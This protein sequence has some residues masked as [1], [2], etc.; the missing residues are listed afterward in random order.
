MNEITLSRDSYDVHTIYPDIASSEHL[1]IPGRSITNSRVLAAPKIKRL[2]ADP[3]RNR[4]AKPRDK[5]LRLSK[6][7]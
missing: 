2:A 3:V 4:Q 5:I 6:E 7:G 1:E